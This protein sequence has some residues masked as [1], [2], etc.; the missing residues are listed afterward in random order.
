MFAGH[1]DRSER[2]CKSDQSRKQRVLDQVL[3][4]LF[5][6]QTAYYSCAR[7]IS[8]WRFNLRGSGPGSVEHN[9]LRCKVWIA[10]EII[11]GHRG[12][13]CGPRGFKMPR[14]RGHHGTSKGELGM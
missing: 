10:I 1:N 7:R 2:R 9:A 4:G 3:T 6:M 8:A 11:P 12:H 13:Q 14:G 5:T